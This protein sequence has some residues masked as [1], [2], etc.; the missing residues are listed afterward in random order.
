MMFGKG[1]DGCGVQRGG[2]EMQKWAIKHD[3]KFDVYSLI[4]RKFH[5]AKG[6]VW[7]NEPIEFEPSQMQDIANRLNNDYDIV[8]YNS[9]PSFK[10][11]HATVNAF[12]K[13]LVCRITKP[14]VVCFMH[15]IKQMNIDCIPLIIPILNR[16][17]LIFNFSCETWFSKTIS[18]ILPSKTLNGRTLRFSLWADIDS[19]SHYRKQYPLASKAKRLTYAG[20]F[21]VSKDPMRM[22]RIYPVL[23]A[24]D[25]SFEVVAHGIEKSIGALVLIKD[26]AVMY[27]D[28]CKQP[29]SYYSKLPIFGP[30]NHDV[31]MKLIG[32]SLFAGSF[33]RLPDQPWN[34]GNRMEYTQI[35]M[36][37]VGSIP[38]FDLHYGQHNIDENGKRYVDNDF[39]AIWSDYNNLRNTAEQLI[40]VAN[41]PKLQKKFREAGLEFIKQE[42]DS[43][44]VLD[45]LFNQITKLGKDPNKYCDDRQLISTLFNP[46]AYIAYEK[47]FDKGISPSVG[48]KQTETKTL[49]KMVGKARVP[50]EYGPQHANLMSFLGS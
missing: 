50:I 44:H 32:E 48:F 37:G 13:D 4:E 30:Y 31:G 7:V 10:H 14:I 2:V 3:H 6:H 42:F 8:I 45:K 27:S 12:Y 49:S 15:E 36:I 34:Y 17:D 23:R 25:P 21:S 38:V 33:F 35:E 46:D 41:S 40:C 26:P 20:R 5:R 47:L 16:A 11:K 9:Y 24:L 28:K 22:L 1:L 19:F 43:E 29:I 18:K 39:L